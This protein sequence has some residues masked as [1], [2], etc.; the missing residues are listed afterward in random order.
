M[1]ALTDQMRDRAGAAGDPRTIAWL[2]SAIMFLDGF[3]IQSIGIAVPH[4]VNSWG[5]PGSAFGVSLTAS[6]VGIGVASAFLAPL[7][8]RFGR[9]PLILFAL[10]VTALG[11]LASALSGD[12]TQ[13]AVAR[14]VTGLGLGASISNAVALLGDVMPPEGRTRRMMLAYVN[15]ALGALSAG[16]VAPWLTAAWGWQ[17]I[18]M[19]GAIGPALL[20]VIA[21]VL[22]PESPH[23]RRGA[24]RTADRPRGTAGVLHPSIRG[25]T[26]LFWML[27]AIT[28]F[29]NYALISWLPALLGSAG[30]SPDQAVRSAALTQ[31]G[32]VIGSLVLA[33][34]VDRGA[35]GRVMATGYAVGTAAALAFL[36]L[37]AAGWTW[38]PMLVLLGAGTSGTYFAFIVV[39]AL[40]YP[41]HLRASGVGWLA[42]AGRI[43][44]ALGPAAGG[45]ML[46]MGVS[47]VHALASVAIPSAIAGTIALRLPA[48]TPDGREETI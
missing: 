20:F 7:G 44:A 16:L 47:P 17:G 9:R 21:V 41:P 14:F 18:F 34:A 36:I 22:L 1:I 35:A 25:L 6:V 42:V 28:A 27:A 5:L 3:D 29:M 4:L 15:V 45:A 26:L 40:A 43:G 46:A 39:G 37:P 13:M 31:L 10:V 8:D 32:A 11:S 38:L 23:F 33:T 2:C 48:R 24:G 30:W 19:A 12:V